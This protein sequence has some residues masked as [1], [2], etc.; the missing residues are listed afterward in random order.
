VQALEEVR[1]DAADGD[2]DGDADRRALK[3][4]TATSLVELSN[5]E[6]TRMGRGSRKD[7]DPDGD[8]EG[9]DDDDCECGGENGEERR[10]SKLLPSLPAMRAAM[11]ARPRSCCCGGGGHRRRRLGGGAYALSL[12]LSLF[13]CPQAARIKFGVPRRRGG[14]LPYFMAFDACLIFV[15]FAALIH[16]VSP[17]SSWVSP[18]H[19]KSG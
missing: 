11:Q 15:M 16:T 9:H 13:L 14:W 18:T 19:G 3:W 7:G 12:S 17:G 6:Y 8:H 4:R 1:L 2:L 10:A 5:R